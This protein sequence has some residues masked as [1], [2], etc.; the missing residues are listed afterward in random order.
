MGL[1]YELRSLGHIHLFS[2]SEKSFEPKNLQSNTYKIKKCI[3]KAYNASNKQ[4]AVQLKTWNFLEQFCDRTLYYV[5][6]VTY[7]K[8]GAQKCSKKLED[9]NCILVFLLCIYTNNIS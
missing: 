5:I 7:Y 8:K 3:Q 9:F 4:V 2:D 6:I 1:Q